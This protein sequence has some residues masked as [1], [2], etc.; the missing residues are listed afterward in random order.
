[1]LK[2]VYLDQKKGFLVKFSNFNIDL[3]IYF[4]RKWHRLYATKLY[5]VELAVGQPSCTMEPICDISNCSVSA[6]PTSDIP[7]V[8]IISTNEGNRFEFQ[9]YYIY[10]GNYTLY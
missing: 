6:K 3:F 4:F 2:L 7:Y 5:T 10:F 8:F 9:A 1:M